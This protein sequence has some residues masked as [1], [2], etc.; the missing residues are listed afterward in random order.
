MNNEYAGANVIHAALSDP[1]CPACDAPIIKNIQCLPAPQGLVSIHFIEDTTY[2]CGLA[3]HSEKR[4]PGAE[5]RR[6]LGGKCQNAFS[7]AV[8]YRK[9]LGQA[10]MSIDEAVAALHGAPENTAGDGTILCGR[11][12]GGERHCLMAKNHDGPHGDGQYSWHA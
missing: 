10:H 3:Y 6:T 12:Q 11:R 2:D 4:N 9:E 1:L 8:A 7:K 5:P